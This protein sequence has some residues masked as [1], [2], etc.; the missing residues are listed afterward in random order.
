[1]K[2]I[3]IVGAG[4]AGL[5]LAHALQSSGIQVTLHEALTLP[6]HRVCGEFICGRGAQA[7][8]A[9]NLG[10][11]LSDAKLHSNILWFDT[12][13]LILK[14]RLPSP[15]YGLSRHQLDLDL[16][17]RF[18]KAGGRLVEN[19]RQTDF[20]S[21]EG[22]VWTS[23][24]KATKTDWIGLKCHGVEMETQADLELHLGNQGYIGLSAIENS[25]VNICGL[26]KRRSDISANKSELLIH[27][28]KACNLHRVAE[29]VSETS[30]DPISHVG[31]AGIQFANKPVLPSVKLCLGDAYSII[32]PFTG[33]GMSIALES[34]V[35][36][37]PLLKEYASGNCTWPKTSQ[38]I[39]ST[40]QKTF[41]RRIRTAS[42]IHPWLHRPTLKRITTVFAKH[43]LIPFKTLYRLTH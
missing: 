39:Y 40:L 24:R 38:L 33:N 17:Q 30:I 21:Q 19:S 6:R 12:S 1:M 9:L 35:I 22:V 29:R 11:C 13:T 23:G 43:R 31:V 41:S 14:N 8:K 10:D 28:L 4:L 36:A 25:K 20:S 3:T 37:H 18:R 16:A 15:A 32:P 7:L 26:F 2:D 42:L 27:Y 5:T 34:A